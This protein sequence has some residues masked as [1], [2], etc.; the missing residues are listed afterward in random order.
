MFGITKTFKFQPK[1]GGGEESVEEALKR[2]KPPPE[3]RAIPQE[4][5]L[6]EE[7]GDDYEEKA[8]APAEEK[9]VQVTCGRIRFEGIVAE[10][11]APTDLICEECE[12]RFASLKC[13]I[14]DQ[15]FC[16][17]CAQLCHMIE[18]EGETKHPHEK[19][20]AVRPLEVGDTSRIHIHKEFNLPEGIFYEEDMAKLRDLSQPNTLSV[21]KSFNQKPSRQVFDAPKFRVGEQLLFRDPVTNEEAFGRVVSEW[22]LRHGRV[23]PSV[24]RGDGTPVMY[25]VDMIAHVKGRVRNYLELVRHPPERQKGNDIPYPRMMNGEG[26]EDIPLRHDK[27]LA[28]DINRRLYDLHEYNAYGP[29][30]HMKKEFPPLNADTGTTYIRYNMLLY[31]LNS[32][33]LFLFFTIYKGG[34]LDRTIGMP[35]VPQPKDEAQVI[36]ELAN[37]FPPESPRAAYLRNH[38]HVIGDGSDAIRGS[39]QH[40][41]SSYILFLIS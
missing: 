33:C 4:S 2:L 14:C 15:V 11:E 41:L 16:S 20:F 9:R 35:E 13:E 12:N 27:Y 36:E 18:E 40:V 37:K 7:V 23:A 34:E 17:K 6:L 1:R 31:I 5:S 28:Q 26:L 3:E 22:D 21:N 29:R 25:L 38:S 39:L 8:E 32:F 30:Y 10:P 19:E 24:V